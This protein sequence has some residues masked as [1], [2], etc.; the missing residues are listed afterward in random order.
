M[1]LTKNRRAMRA[2]ILVELLRE[3][4]ELPDELVGWQQI[5]NAFAK[6][7]EETVAPIMEPEDNTFISKNDPHWDIKTQHNETVKD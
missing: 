7:M 3:S 4:L 6:L 1:A 2:A 5:A